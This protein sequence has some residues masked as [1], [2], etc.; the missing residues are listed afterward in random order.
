MAAIHRIFVIER[1]RFFKPFVLILALAVLTLPSCETG[2]N[3]N[4]SGSS[5]SGTSS[6]SGAYTLSDGSTVSDTAGTTYGSTASNVSAIYVTNGTL[7]L[8]SPTITK[9]GDLSGSSESKT[10]V[11]A[12]VRA[13]SSSAKINI[14]GGTIAS[15][16]TGGNAVM[17]YDSATA[18]LSG[19]T[20]TNT[21]SG[22]CRALYAVEKGIINA[23]NVT[24]S[25]T[26]SSSSVV[27]TDTGG[28]TITLTGGSFSASGQNSAGLYSTGTITG[29]GITA[30]SA[31]GEACVIEGS[32]SITL[33]G[34][35]VLKSG[36]SNR[37]IMMLQSGSGDAGT[38]YDAI[39]TMT[40]GS[41]T[42]TTS[43]LTNSTN[44]FYSTAPLVPLFEVV[45]NAVATITLTDVA[46]T[47]A[48]G[49]LMEVDYNTQWSTNG[50]KGT[51]ILQTADSSNG[52]SVTGN[53]IADGYSTAALTVGSGVTWTGAFDATNVAKSGAVTI[54]TG[55]TW[56]LS[57]NSNV[58]TLS[59]NGTITLGGHTLSVNGTAWTGR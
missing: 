16:A 8:T 39:F 58:D 49:V 2:T 24:A 47:S 56:V 35:S 33:S 48:S 45:C 46:L 42:T 15:S 55:G 29:S 4:S 52:Y 10:G 36:A 53:V 44:A 28:G 26:G 57:G 20:I 14:T 41:I 32:N 51:M 43:A 7:T 30:T 40:G 50:A 54:A 27:A 25:T 38:G 37:G 5:N 31:I 3:S 21:G 13:S 22:D 6:S 34:S 11:N 23:T 18:T 59:N 9:S 17:A 12:A 19:V 1:R